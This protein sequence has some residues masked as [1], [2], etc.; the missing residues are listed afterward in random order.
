MQNFHGCGLDFLL[1][2]HLFSSSVYGSLFRP[3]SRLR[4]VSSKL[5]RRGFEGHVSYPPTPLPG[6]NMPLDETQEIVE[7]V[8][9]GRAEGAACGCTGTRGRLTL[10]CPSRRPIREPA[11]KTHRQGNVH[12]HLKASLALIASRGE[13]L[14][15]NLSFGDQLTRTRGREQ[16]ELQGNEHHVQT[17]SIYPSNP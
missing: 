6:H 8:A 16:R 13:M 9:Y 11:T 2:F 17:A 14:K 15:Q 7:G 5:T 12:I 10:R 1:L 3:S 4:T